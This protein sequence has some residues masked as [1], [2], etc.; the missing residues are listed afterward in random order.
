MEATVGLEIQ[1]EN[2][3]AA[4]SA[5][6][7][8]YTARNRNR[9]ESREIYP[10]EDPQYGRSPWDEFR[11]TIQPAEEEGEDPSSYTLRITRHATP[12]CDSA[13]IKEL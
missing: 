12:L 4:Q 7:A 8:L 6:F 3:T 5:R 10:P 1:Y 13:A 11:V 2:R 9:V